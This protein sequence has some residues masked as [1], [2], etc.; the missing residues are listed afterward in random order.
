[1][2]YCTRAISKKQVQLPCVL[3]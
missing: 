2:H 1:M 3:H